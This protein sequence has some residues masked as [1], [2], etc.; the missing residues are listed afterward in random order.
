M[1]S[2]R[3]AV[4]NGWESSSNR[5]GIYTSRIVANRQVGACKRNLASFRDALVAEMTLFNANP[6]NSNTQMTFDSVED[7][8]WKCNDKVTFLMMLYDHVVEQAPPTHDSQAEEERE[9]A[10]LETVRASVVEWN[11]WLI[12]RKEA[13]AT[14]SA[15]MV[16]RENAK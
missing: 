8:I 15:D 4:R 3:Q 16:E 9:A 6:P 7:Y 11:Q 13:W 12:A 10:Y 14:M 5:L 2:A 1:S